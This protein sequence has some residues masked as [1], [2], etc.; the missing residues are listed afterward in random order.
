MLWCQEFPLICLLQMRE[1]SPNLCIRPFEA[2][3]L[4]EPLRVNV[5][6]LPGSSRICHCF[7]IRCKETFTSM[8]LCLPKSLSPTPEHP[9]DFPSSLLEGTPS[10]V[11]IH[12]DVQGV[13]QFTF[14]CIP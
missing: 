5:P 9:E 14:A 3:L 13:A 10:A 8:S 2:A 4:R 6:R 11:E 12:T 7:K 1:L